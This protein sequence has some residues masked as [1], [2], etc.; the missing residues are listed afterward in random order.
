[1]FWRGVLLTTFHLT[2][3]GKLLSDQI[4]RSYKV[5]EKSRRKIT[6]LGV[7]LINGLGRL[8]SRQIPTVGSVGLVM[9]RLSSKVV[10]GNSCSR[11]IQLHVQLNIAHLGFCLCY[12]S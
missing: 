12:L 5:N 3:A 6:L 4:Y 2:D 7:W 8:V 10:N 11:T 1:V 9:N